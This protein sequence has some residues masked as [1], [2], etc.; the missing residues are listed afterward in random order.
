ML[1]AVYLTLLTRGGVYNLSRLN[2]SS[3]PYV[4]RGSVYSLAESVDQNVFM[5][6]HVQDIHSG[7]KIYNKTKTKCFTIYL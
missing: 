3:L 7:C 1:R 5:N 6:V 2:T 4:V